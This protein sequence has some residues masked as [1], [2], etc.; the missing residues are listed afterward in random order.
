LS[1]ILL[2]NKPTWDWESKSRENMRVGLVEKWGGVG[3]S[4]WE[5]LESGA[6]KEH[7]FDSSRLIW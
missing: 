3:A 7:V 1:E 5:G 6:M 2:R 4:D